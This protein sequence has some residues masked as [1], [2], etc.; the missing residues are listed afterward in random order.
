MSSP[1]LPP[2][3]KF[4][5]LVLKGGVTSG[6]VYPAAIVVLSKA[7]RFKSIGGTSIGAAGAALTAAAEYARR[8][9]NEYSFD[10]LGE[11]LTQAFSGQGDTP[12]LLPRFQPAPGTRRLFNV[13]ISSLERN[14]KFGIGGGVIG[15][16][17]LTGG[18][19]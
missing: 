15:G 9:G 14:S 7:Y 11:D 8:H 3:D 17:A 10:Q 1:P 2:K 16:L 5:D 19:S 12:P 18:P 6:V 4:C 13:F